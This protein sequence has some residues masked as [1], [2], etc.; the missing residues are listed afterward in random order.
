MAKPT[1]IV[2]ASIFSRSGYGDHGRSICKALIQSDLYDVKIVP[3]P[4]GSTPDTALDPDNPAHR[5][6]FDRIIPG[7][8]QEND[9]PDIF[10][11]VTIPSEF[12]P[13]GKLSIGIT[14]GIECSKM[15]PE[16]IE[17]CNKM[18][19]V[20]TTS[21]FSAEVFKINKFERRNKQ[22][23]QLEGLVEV[24]KPL[25]VLFEGF[26]PV[27]FNK[28]LPLQ[29]SVADAMRELPDF[30]FL[31]CGHWLQG[32]LGH[33]RKDVGMLVKVF[34]DT[35]KRKSEKNRPGLILKTGLAGFSIT[36]REIIRDKIEQVT[37]IIRAEGWKKDLPPIYI[38]NGELSD[39]EM[40]SL[41]NHPK[42]K[43]MVSFTHGEGFGRPLLEFTTTGKPVIASQWSGQIDFL[44]PDYSFLLP[45][46]LIKVDRSAQNEWIVDG[47]WFQVNYNNAAN[48]LLSCHAN[49]AAFLE[50]SRKHRKITFD[51]FT[52][53][54]MQD[55]LIE[56]LQKY[57]HPIPDSGPVVRKLTLPKLTKVT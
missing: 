40:N 30:N 39:E 10:I 45:G 42:V 29:K 57:Q 44:H 4:W 16:W 43:A 53:E 5:I 55:K 48:I 21:R 24:N 33:D 35:F 49:Y 3:L 6:F 51:N 2:A 12:Q 23:N 22:T 18:D 25:E 17:G 9:R 27:V 1:C 50:K 20:I 38:L 19:L 37:D 8:I 7:Q 13:A 41:Y 11:H 34:L 32:M 47:E 54:K 26:D 52:E 56:I 15:R 36:E 46:Q 28:S 31:F 14:A